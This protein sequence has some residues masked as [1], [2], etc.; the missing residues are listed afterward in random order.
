MTAHLQEVAMF[1]RVSMAGDFV[2][3]LQV[4][5]DRAARTGLR[6]T[7]VG[8]DGD[9]DLV[10]SGE[11]VNTWSDNESWEIRTPAAGLP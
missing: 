3:A 8:T 7:R 1:E 5:A 2:L 4:S 9:Q 10:V 11:K 6:L